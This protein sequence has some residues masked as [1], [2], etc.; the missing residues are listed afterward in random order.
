MAK[1]IAKETTQEWVKALYQ[2]IGREKV[3]GTMVDT[4]DFIWEFTKAQL[5]ER[6]AQAQLIVDEYNEKIALFN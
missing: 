4:I 5:E 1:F 2:V 3:D 6:K